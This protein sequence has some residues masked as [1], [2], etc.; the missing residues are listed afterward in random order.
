MTRKEGRDEVNVEDATRVRLNKRMW[1]RQENLQIKLRLSD[2]H[3][4]GGGGALA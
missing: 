1:R 4:G 3:S 2:V